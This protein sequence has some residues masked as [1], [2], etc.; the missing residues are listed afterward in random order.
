MQSPLSDLTSQ[1]NSEIW[2][3]KISGH[4]RR[5]CRYQKGIRIRKSKTQH[6]GLID[7]EYT[8]KWKL[9]LWSH[10]TSYYLIEV[11]TKAGMTIKLTLTS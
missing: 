3:H 4:L 1:G 9:K 8:V 6:N 11:V 7:I 10:N 5:V 2:S